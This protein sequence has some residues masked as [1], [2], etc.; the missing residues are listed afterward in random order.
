MQ[1]KETNLKNIDEI[2]V[3]S[4][5]SQ[6]DEDMLAEEIAVSD[7]CCVRFKERSERCRQKIY[8]FCVYASKTDEMNVFCNFVSKQKI[9]MKIK[10]S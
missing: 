9:L 10:N 5:L 8:T 1:D 2:I 6:H 4:E 3:D 7:S